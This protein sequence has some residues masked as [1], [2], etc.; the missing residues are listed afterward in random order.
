MPVFEEMM[1]YDG[2]RAPNPRRVQVFMAEKGIEIPRREIDINKLEQKSEWFSKINPLQ[3]VPVLV[4]EDGTAI[5]ETVAICRYLE[6][7]QPEPPLMGVDAKDRALVEMWQRRVELQFLLP[8]GFAFR[9]L[10]RGAVHLEQPQIGEWGTVNQT[11]AREFMEYLDGELANRRYIAGDAF[12]IADITAV[13]AYQFLRPGR[14]D[15]PLDLA[16]LQ[17]WFGE[18]SER[19]SV[20]LP[21]A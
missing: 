7:I 6:E 17:R 12:S 2:G 13:I 15:Y 21:A 3:R 11:R 9:H 1:L 18:V 16:N 14:I 4:L 20:K 5:C 10:H 8:V 19:P